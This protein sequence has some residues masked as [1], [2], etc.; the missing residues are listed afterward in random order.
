MLIEH[1]TLTKERDFQQKNGSNY[2]S[3]N[4]AFGLENENGFSISK[5]DLPENTLFY[6]D[7]ISENSS[8][9]CSKYF[10]GKLEILGQV[11]TAQE[12]REAGLEFDE[13]QSIPVYRPVYD[14]N[15]AGIKTKVKNIAYETGYFKVLSEADS[16]FLSYGYSR[17]NEFGIR[18]GK[19]QVIPYVFNVILPS[20][21]KK[22][23]INEETDRNSPP[24]IFFYAQQQ[25]DRGDQIYLVLEY[26]V[27]HICPPVQGDLNALVSC[28]QDSTDYSNIQN[29]VLQA[30]CT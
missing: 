23:L 14:V 7:S 24:S 9:D 17:D 10:Y 2:Y 19:G 27:A 8:Q 28:E 5:L 29:S 26:I 1:V 22:K 20:P 4:G 13:S 16:N 18:K 15:E 3:I 11:C 30:L 6:V 25:I 21:I 12:F